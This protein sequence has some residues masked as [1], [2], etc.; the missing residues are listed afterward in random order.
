MSNEENL[1]I[2]QPDPSWDYYIEWHKLI[3]ANAQLKELIE[4]ISKIE[5]AR[6]DVQEILRQDIS[7]IIATLADI[8]PPDEL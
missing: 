8:I 2:P 5:N 6:E 3:R 7:K 1:N 4:F